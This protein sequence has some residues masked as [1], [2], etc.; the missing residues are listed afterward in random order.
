[1]TR[2]N[3]KYIFLLVLSVILVGCGNQPT[4]V[5][6]SEDTK[7]ISENLKT[8]EFIE[9]IVEADE[10]KETEEESVEAV[11]PDVVT[12]EKSTEENSEEV[13]KIV[14][15]DP[16]KRPLTDED[17]PVIILDENSEA[18]IKA[19]YG[20]ADLQI[21]DDLP[22]NEDIVCGTRLHSDK[23]RRFLT[24]VYEDSGCT[25]HEIIEEYFAIN[26]VEMQDYSLAVK[27]PVGMSYSMCIAGDWCYAI[28]HRN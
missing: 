21:V 25:S 14:E 17:I 10:V 3:L 16:A 27:T 18:T 13:E 2:S 28:K 12:T 23:V 22:I 26:E 20:L 11:M 19:L 9:A 24:W 1:M 8:S 7:P 15:E 5:Q 6:Y 4:E